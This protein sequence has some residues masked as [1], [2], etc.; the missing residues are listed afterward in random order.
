LKRVTMTMQQNIRKRKALFI[1]I[2]NIELTAYVSAYKNT[3][4]A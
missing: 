1:G 4:L 2:I 3:L